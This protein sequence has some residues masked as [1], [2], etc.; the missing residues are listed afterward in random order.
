MEQKIIASRFN[1]TASTC[2]KNILKTWLGWKGQASGSNGLRAIK[3]TANGIK[4][5]TIFH[6]IRERPHLD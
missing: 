1:W 3:Y 6:L 5:T 2:T 4:G